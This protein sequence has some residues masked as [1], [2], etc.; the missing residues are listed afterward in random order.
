MSKE[1]KIPGIIDVHVHLRDPGA[2]H[3]EDFHAGTCAA[4][5]GG[6]TVV[7]DMPNNP[8]PTVSQGALEEKMRIAKQKAVCDYGFYLGADQ[9]NASRHGELTNAVCGLKIYL[10]STHGSLLVNDLLTLMRHFKSWSGQKPICVH[11]EDISVAKVLG[12]AAVYQKPV[13]FCHVAQASE[14]SLI[15]MA[16]KR[17]L[18]ITCEVTPHHLFLTQEDETSLGVFGAMKP[19]LRTKEDQEALWRAIDEGTVDVIA[20]DHAPHTKEEKLGEKPPFG[21]PGLETTLSLLLTVVAEGRLT[22]EK[23]IELTS[24]NPA[25]I[26]GLTQARDTSYLMVDLEEKWEIPQEGFQTKCNWSPFSGF[27]VQ[28][29][30]REVWMRG[31]KVWDGEKVLVQPGFGKEVIYAAD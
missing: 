9:E 31:R 3:K 20:S 27:Q 22:M 15:R 25:K 6:V 14:I 5:A 30:V 1:V 2:T 4:L 11:A 19:P 28:G 18:P 7:L 29:K 24:S 21:V 8:Q 26:F 12:L 10:D 23:L 13:H 17:E 16:K